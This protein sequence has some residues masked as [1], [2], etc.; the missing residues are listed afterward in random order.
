M[1]IIKSTGCTTHG[2]RVDGKL[3][4][5]LSHQEQLEI[6]ENIKNHYK[7]YDIIDCLVDS[8]GEFDCEDTPCDQCG[9]SVSTS[10]LI[11]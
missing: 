10:T 1:K 7:I 8:L 5:D 9:D 2:I 3:L 4:Q 6:L 11:V